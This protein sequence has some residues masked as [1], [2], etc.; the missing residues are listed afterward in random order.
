MIAGTYGDFSSQNIVNDNNLKDPVSILMNIAFESF[1]AE[2]QFYLQIGMP[3]KFCESAEQTTELLKSSGTFEE[4]QKELCL[5]VFGASH[6]EYKFL[7]YFYDSNFIKA[8]SAQTPGSDLLKSLSTDLLKYYRA[9]GVAENENNTNDIDFDFKDFIKYLE[10]KIVDDKLRISI[11]K[12][13]QNQIKAYLISYIAQKTNEINEAKNLVINGIYKDIPKKIVEYIKS[14]TNP[15][16]NR[17]YSVL[18][19]A[20]I[21]FIDD[22]HTFENQ[23]DN[24]VKNVINFIGN[25][26]NTMEVPPDLEKDIRDQLMNG[27]AFAIA[28]KNTDIEVNGKVYK[29]KGSGGGYKQLTSQNSSKEVLQLTYSQ[30]IELSKDKPFFLKDIKLQ[31]D[32][33]V[34]STIF[35]DKIKNQIRELNDGYDINFELDNDELTI[36]ND[37]LYMDRN[38]FFNN[39]MKLKFDYSKYASK[40]YAKNNENF[41]TDKEIMSNIFYDTLKGTLQ[42]NLVVKD[43]QVDVISSF[44]KWWAEKGEKGFLKMLDN[45]PTQIYEIASKSAEANVAGMLGE[46]LMGL[47]LSNIEIPGS[48]VKVLG[49][50]D[51]G[52]GQAAVDLKIM[53]PDNEGS[54]KTAGFQIKQYAASE[55][56]GNKVDLYSDTSLK[57]SDTHMARYLEATYLEK[58]RAIFFKKDYESYWLNS[59]EG[60]KNGGIENSSIEETKNILNAHLM[61]FMRYD[62]AQMKNGTFDELEQNNF[63]IINFRFIPASSLFILA[64]FAIEDQLGIEMTSTKDFFFFSETVKHVGKQNNMMSSLIRYINLPE[65]QEASKSDNLCEYMIDDFRLNFVGFS[66]NFKQQLDS[67]LKN[68][69]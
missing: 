36:S 22:A 15:K 5:R 30:I 16:D 1:K 8:L 54:I 66:V 67:V 48:V 28:T 50:S 12:I 31:G 42:N 45:N 60:S 39:M 37:R 53:F 6:E 19:L 44:N 46:T 7:K 56:S 40:D 43:N 65:V 35:T 26:L 62:E 64:A 10:S 58:I 18:K 59:T 61:Y 29:S 17:G 69:K 51:H 13:N 24:F 21:Q 55:S 20:Q 23:F 32:N 38:M 25:Q 41:Q 11:K 14:S 47:F 49:Q 33:K 57:L 68:T 34:I 52:N 63:Y 4:Y 27:V 2:Q 9:I 3:K